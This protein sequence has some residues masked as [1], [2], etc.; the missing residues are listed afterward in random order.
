MEVMKS[1]SESLGMNPLVV[2]EKQRPEE[3]E[4]E[5]ITVDVEPEELTQEEKDAEEDFAFSRKNIKSV[6]EKGGD[7]L[8]GILRLAEASEHPKAY[9]VVATMIKNLTE[10]NKQLLE[11]HE[12]RRELAPI[13]T[14]EA[15]EDSKQITNN[16]VFVGTTAELLELI[17]AGKNPHEVKAIDG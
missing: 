3:I 15:K 16:N 8:E 10:S 14:E 4:G 7:A 9:E 17:K 11:L 1:I 13:K 5:M 12:K 6:L 2:D